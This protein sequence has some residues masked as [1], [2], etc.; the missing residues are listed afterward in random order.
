VALPDFFVVGAPKAG[1]T[2]LHAA[3][4]RQPGLF[5]SPVKEP[6]FF[7]GD[8]RPPPRF[9]GPG[10]AHSAREW[11]WRRSDHEALFDGA[12]PTTCRCSRR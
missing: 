11:V 6:T 4:A 10:D 12:P 1:T 9:R 7:L 5:L 3:L 8:G 2:A